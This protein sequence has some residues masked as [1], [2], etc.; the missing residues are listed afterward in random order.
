MAIQYFHDRKK[1]TIGLKEERFMS[2]DQANEMR[3]DR[4][5]LKDTAALEPGPLDGIDFSLFGSRGGGPG[6]LLRSRL[7][8][9]VEWHRAHMTELDRA[10]VSI[11]TVNDRVAKSV[12]EVERIFADND[13][14]QD[15]RI[16]R[17]SDVY[18]VAVD[19]C[20][21]WLL[22]HIKEALNTLEQAEQLVRLAEL[23]EKKLD[24][25]DSVRELRMAEVRGWF[26]NLLEAIQGET[27]ERLGREARLEQLAAVQNDPC[28]R[29][30]VPKL[31]V[32]GARV[33]A[34]RAQNGDFC[35]VELMDS[36]DF[37]DSLKWRCIGLSR[38]LRGWAVDRGLTLA[39]GTNAF[40][41]IADEALA[42]S[43]DFLRV[44]EDR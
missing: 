33:A 13:L 3:H 7:R 17:A 34:I 4:N 15:G 21:H 16:R 43:E 18:Q 31:I 36:R 30:R 27:L 11:V 37:L 1:F 5:L 14:S 44:V 35:L 32:D 38:L 19:V 22:I 12:N 41:S 8:A 39:E 9:D 2:L 24:E 10:L 25:S 6:I 29:L 40:E 26:F 20:E 28:G 42:R 23:P